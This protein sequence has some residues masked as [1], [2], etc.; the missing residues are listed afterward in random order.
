[1]R[2]GGASL[3]PVFP[4]MTGVRMVEGE[5]SGRGTK[6]APHRG[7]FLEPRGEGP[8]HIQFSE[9]PMRFFEHVKAPLLF[10]AE[11]FPEMSVNSRICELQ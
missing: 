4:D 2:Y 8:A 3:L 6:P 11:G 1:M 7:R 9:L 5:E 10:G